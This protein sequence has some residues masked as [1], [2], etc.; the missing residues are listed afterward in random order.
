MFFY[1]LARAGEGQVGQ[2]VLPVRRPAA[3]AHESI[4]V[5]AGFARLLSR[6][7]LRLQLACLLLGLL[8]TDVAVP[9]HFLWVQ[10]L[11]PRMHLTLFCSWLGCQLLLICINSSEVVVQLAVVFSEW[12]PYQ[13]EEAALRA[14]PRCSFALRRNHGIIWLLLA[15]S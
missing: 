14:F 5:V 6:S 2:G 3:V 1:S 11:A 8:A 15:S 12:M 7:C 13:G 9:F 4:L 10:G